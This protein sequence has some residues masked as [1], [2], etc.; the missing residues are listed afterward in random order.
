MIKGLGEFDTW[1]KIAVA[2]T[3]AVVPKYHYIGQ[4]HCGSQS[5]LSIAA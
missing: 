2:V 5:S 1:M 3:I 4:L